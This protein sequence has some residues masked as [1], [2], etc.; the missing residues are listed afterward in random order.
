[1]EQI[2]NFCEAEPKQA[3][4]VGDRKLKLHLNFCSHPENIPHILSHTKKLDTQPFPLALL[5]FF[6]TISQSSYVFIKD[7]ICCEFVT[8]FSTRHSFL[9]CF[10]LRTS[11][12]KIFLFPFF[13]TLL[14]KVGFWSWLLW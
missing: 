7:K 11:V 10:Q 6:S 3:C 5:H 4:D 13:V 14:H 8:R 9:H 12:L 2:Y 1:M